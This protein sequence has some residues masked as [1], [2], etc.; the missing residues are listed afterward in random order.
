MSTESQNA[1]SLPCRGDHE[2]VS[3]PVWTDARIREAFLDDGGQAAYHDP[4]NGEKEQRRIAGAIFDEWLASHD[5][6]VRAA[7]DWRVLGGLVP[8][9][10]NAAWLR[11]GDHVRINRFEGTVLDH[12]IVHV[13]H[14]GRLA[15]FA[16][17]T[18]LGDRV[19]QARALDSEVLVLPAGV[20]RG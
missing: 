11:N 17:E 4:I 14:I 7:V 8:G 10:I 19:H 2:T 1:R 15:R 13:E 18:D 20:N 12:H 6:A 16:V 5:E 9:V 3:A